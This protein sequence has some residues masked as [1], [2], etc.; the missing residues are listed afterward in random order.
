MTSFPVEIATNS[1]NVLLDETDTLDQDNSAPS[2]SSYG[3][4]TT[5]DEDNDNDDDDEED[6][7]NDDDWSQASIQSDDSAQREKWWQQQQEKLQAQLQEEQKQQEQDQA[8]RVKRSKSFGGLSSLSNIGDVGVRAAAA[9]V[10]AEEAADEGTPSTTNVVSQVPSKPPLRRTVSSSSDP[11]LGPIK[12]ALRRTSLYGS[13]T[14]TIPIN[15]DRRAWKQMPPPKGPEQTPSNGRVPRKKRGS[16]ARAGVAGIV[17][18]VTGG[19]RRTKSTG[20]LERAAKA[21]TQH[22]QSE[23]QSAHQ[24]N[25]P[26]EYEDANQRQHV[27]VPRKP[28]RRVSFGSVGIR[29]H[30]LTIGD[31][32]SC[33]SGAPTSLDW[34]YNEK[35]AVHIE[36]YEFHRRPVRK[37]SS[38][39][40]SMNANLRRDLL[41]QSGKTLKEIKQATE[42]TQKARKQREF[43]TEV[44]LPL[45]QVEVVMES[46]ARKAK[47]LLPFSGGLGKG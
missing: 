28:R 7:D 20:E 33:R 30:A 17:G 36:S 4:F 46:A 24:P 11:G 38:R 25:H 42:Q 45:E 40:L 18:V 47:R 15:M 39:E 9:A 32:P 41:L 34:E 16:F 27:W 1:T 44:M 13:S 43:T 8:K 22:K 35:D 31:N 6:D 3:N 37:T 12:S 10:A 21:A 2:S 14:D 19:V 5:D 26:Q 23:Q 29:E